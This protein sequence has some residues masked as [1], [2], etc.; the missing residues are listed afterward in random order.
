MFIGYVYMPMGVFI[1]THMWL[2]WKPF[3]GCKLSR[4]ISQMQNISDFFTLLKVIL[5]LPH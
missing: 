3:Q 4:G 5:R 1:I 2:I